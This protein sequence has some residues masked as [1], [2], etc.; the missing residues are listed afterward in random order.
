MKIW[1]CALPVFFSAGSFGPSPLRWCRFNFKTLGF[2]AQTARAGFPIFA[3]KG[4]ARRPAKKATKRAKNKLI[5]RRRR[6]EDGGGKV[7]IPWILRPVATEVGGAKR[8]WAG[9]FFLA[10]KKNVRSRTR[11]GKRTPTTFRKTG[12]F[13]IIAPLGANIV[14][15]IENVKSNL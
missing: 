8:N 2:L 3:N 15:R 6:K 9:E 7:L 5:G 11:R 1:N 12:L 10:S 4:R 13:I 14:S